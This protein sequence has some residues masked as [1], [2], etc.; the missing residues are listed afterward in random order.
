MKEVNDEDNI[1]NINISN[2]NTINNNSQR[3][4]N[5]KVIMKC[6]QEFLTFDKKNYPKNNIH[7]FRY[8]NIFF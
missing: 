2:I 8:Y 1:D 4:S 7:T 3:D 6:N 5:K